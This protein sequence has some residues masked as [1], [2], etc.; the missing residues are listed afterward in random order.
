MTWAAPKENVPSKACDQRRI[1]SAESSLISRIRLN[2]HCLFLVHDEGS[3][4]LIRVLTI[5]TTK[6]SSLIWNCSI[7]E[8]FYVFQSIHKTHVVYSIRFALL[9]H[10]KNITFYLKKSIEGEPWSY[11]IRYSQSILFPL[12]S[13]SKTK[14]MVEWLRLLTLLL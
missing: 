13:L 7:F 2:L 4:T 10:F 3:N 9:N 6:R 8:N 1:K 11:I 5:E 14:K 12:T